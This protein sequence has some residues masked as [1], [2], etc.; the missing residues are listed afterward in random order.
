MNQVGSEHGNPAPGPSDPANPLF[1]SSIW[2]RE[3]ENLH[4][5]F[6]FDEEE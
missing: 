5:F 4:Y 2:Q 1:S 6:T 3:P